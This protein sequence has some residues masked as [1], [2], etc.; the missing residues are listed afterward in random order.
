MRNDQPKQR[1]ASPLKK[2]PPI[3][4]HAFSPRATGWMAG[5]GLGA[6]MG[7]QIEVNH[8]KKGG[9]QLKTLSARVIEK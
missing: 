4:K 9:V 5:E 8:A 2:G 6:N 7:G 3:C 1:N